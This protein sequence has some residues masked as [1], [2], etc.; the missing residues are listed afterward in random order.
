MGYTTEFQG[1]VE[2][3]APLSTAQALYVNK[4]SSTR[5]MKRDAAKA[6]QLADLVGKAINMPIGEEACYFVGGS[7]FAGQ[8]DDASVIDHNEPPVGQPG[9]WCQWVVADDGRYLQWNG[10]E[11]FYNYVEWMRY[12][13]EH[14]FQPWGCTL[15]GEIEWQGEN[16][17]DI[18]LIKV[19]ENVVTS[20]TLS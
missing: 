11:K 9:L 12:L 17:D 13:I 8:D 20:R 15:N 18:G 3:N 19:T 6:L 14:F 4:F 10:T 16:E 7:G 5:R 2:I 1:K